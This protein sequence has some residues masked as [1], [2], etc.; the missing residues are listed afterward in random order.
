MKIGVVS[1]THDNI[2]AI[3]A[4]VALLRH[5]GVELLIHCGDLESADTAAYFRDIVTH[6]VQGNCDDPLPILKP[7]VES[8]GGVLHGSVGFLD[9]SGTRIAWTHGHEVSCL[10]QLETSGAYDFVFHGHTHEAGQFQK[11]ATWVINP[12]ALYRAPR[13]TCV[14]L[15]VRSG[16]LEFVEIT[17]GAGSRGR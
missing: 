5:R 7:S 17:K 9:L 11:G 10:R 6:F 14:V 2:V 3:Q 4:A 8:H 12:G 16:T 15:D 1:D 13:Y